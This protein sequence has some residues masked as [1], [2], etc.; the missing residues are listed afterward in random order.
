M[1]RKH[2]K[3]Q[4]TGVRSSGLMLGKH[5]REKKEKNA[6][7]DRT[8]TVYWPMVFH[9]PPLTLS[10]ILGLFF[11]QVLPFSRSGL[12]NPGFFNSHNNAKVGCS[13]HV[14]EV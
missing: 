12:S 13:N 8:K 10:G 6:F 14:A 5:K 4:G 1:F 2:K 9:F 7:L 3:L 11:D